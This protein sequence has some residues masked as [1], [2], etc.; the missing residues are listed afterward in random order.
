M[1]TRTGLLVINH[2]NSPQAFIVTK[3]RVPSF[4]P[5]TLSLSTVVKSAEKESSLVAGA[6][7]PTPDEVM[8]EEEKSATTHI[9][10]RQG[11]L[12]PAELQEIE[13]CLRLRAVLLCVYASAWGMGGHLVGEGSRVMCSAHVRQV[14]RCILFCA[15]CLH[16]DNMCSQPSER[17][18]KGNALFCF[19]LP[20][21]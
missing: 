12:T 17:V 11:D 1:R 7:E 16:V 8:E 3:I 6:D 18:S 10:A 5:N 20:P 21:T 4:S 15:R 14:G 9:I 19:V 2:T 13:K